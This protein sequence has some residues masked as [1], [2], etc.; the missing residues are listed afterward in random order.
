MKNIYECSIKKSQVENRTVQYMH[1]MYG[2]NDAKIT[3]IGRKKCC[4]IELNREK[5]YYMYPQMRGIW[6]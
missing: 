6:N 2:N 5:S 4:N 1:L 3:N